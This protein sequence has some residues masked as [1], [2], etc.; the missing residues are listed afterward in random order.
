MSVLYCSG[1][2]FGESEGVNNISLEYGRVLFFTIHSV[3]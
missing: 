1:V 3:E 2:V